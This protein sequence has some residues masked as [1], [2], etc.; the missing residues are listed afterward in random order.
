MQHD[1]VHHRAL[2]VHRGD[3]QGHLE[4]RVPSG[5]GDTEG[6]FHLRVLAF[7]EVSPC[8]VGNDPYFVL[9][10]WVARDQRDV[11]GSGDGGGARFLAR[12]QRF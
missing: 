4:Q 1:H 6:A 5:H 2:H 11:D 9:Q 3:H 8:E 12:V 10:D 7:R